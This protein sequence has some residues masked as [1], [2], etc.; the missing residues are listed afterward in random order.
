MKLP[1][2]G[3][4]DYLL[5]DLDKEVWREPILEPPPR[6]KAPEPPPRHD[7][8]PHPPRV[9]VNIEIVEYH[10]GR[11]PPALRRAFSTAWVLAIVIWIVVFAVLSMLHRAHAQPSHWR[12]YTAQ[13]TTHMQGEDSDGGA[14]SGRQY[15]LGFT[16]YTD[17]YGPDGEVKHCQSYKLGFNTYADCD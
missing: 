6:P 5:R 1:A 15:R 16:T 17:F 9:T 7:D 12:S 4:F 10:R 3:D 11:H 14:W 13:G 8:P 2:R